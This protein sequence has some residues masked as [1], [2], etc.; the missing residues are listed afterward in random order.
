[1]EKRKFVMS[2][3]FGKDSTLALHKMIRENNAEP[4]ALLVMINKDFERSFFHGIDYKMMECVSK[5]LGIPLLHCVSQGDNYNQ[6][7]ED[8]LKKARELG[9]EVAVF[10][11]IDIS[12]HKT[13]CT[14]R[15]E[16]ASIDLE[17][18]LWHKPREV[19]VNEVLSLGYK[20]IIKTVNNTL[21]PKE[22]L[23]EI[24]DFDTLKIFEKHNVDIC[25]EYGEY[26]TFVVD[27]PLFKTRINY[28]IG[29]KLD[30]GVTSV[31]DI[32]NSDK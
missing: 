31:V 19:I 28:T 21:L 25:G 26:H 22:L 29:D 18:P 16:N 24:I 6:I 15:C 23:G 5:S 10:G 11:D 20:C 13:W 32:Y 14:Q 1:M 7:M 17:F 4:V 12:D 27:G 3:S 8:G 2:Y 9:A 30:F